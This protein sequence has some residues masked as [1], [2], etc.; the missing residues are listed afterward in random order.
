MNVLVERFKKLIILVF[1]LVLAIQSVNA[2][3][4]LGPLYNRSGLTL[5]EGWR[6]EWFGPF[7]YRE[8]SDSTYTV[9][10]PPLFSYYN[11]DDV[12][13]RGFD[14]LYPVIGYREYDNEY[15]FNIFQIFSF[16]GGSTGDDGHAK[17][18]T[19]FPFYFQQR[20]T[21]PEENY[22]A[23]VPFYGT[24][25][26]RLFYEEV[27]FVMF[28]IYSQTKKKGAVTDNYLVPIF[29]IRHGMGLKGWQ[30]F[31]LYGHE[32]KTPFSFTNKYDELEFSPGHEKRFIL[33]PLYLESTTGIG[34]T[35]QLFQRAILPF[36][37]YQESELRHSITAPWPIGLTLT[38]DEEKK[39]NEIGFPW[40]LFVI[41]RGEGKNIT[42]FWPIYG[43][44]SNPYKQSDF[45]LWPIY[46]YNKLITDS[47]DIE[48]VRIALFLY[49]DSVT[50]KK[51]NTNTSRRT[52]LWPLFHHYIDAD[53]KQKLTSP[54]LLEPIFPSNKPI[55][56]NYSP[57]W[58][59]CREEKNLKDG[60]Y[61]KSL[62]WNLLRED[63]TKEKHKCSALFGLIQVE[64]T[65]DSTK[66]KLFHIPVSNKKHTEQKERKFGVESN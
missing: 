65:Q 9:G 11:D 30:V 50:T 23:I 14:F 17:R 15:R 16:S 44:A 52:S 21:V 43:T 7:F 29:H 2:D 35:N 64:K 24:L 48:R 57:L 53:G 56:R 26:N 28:P 34:S 22:L 12:K 40:P 61:S 31:P 4:S 25:K 32:V 8:L 45:Y 46:K 39:Y 5:T 51:D 27:H 55:E 60:K 66:V 6:E 59:L 10:V 42:R 37:S 54:A 62:F 36:F 58:G 49:S 13:R 33:W 20:S 41:A 38:R 63:T 1:G 19:I 47:E 3:L 18:T